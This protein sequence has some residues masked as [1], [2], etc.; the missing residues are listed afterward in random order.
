M[1]IYISDKFVPGTV[2]PRE[3]AKDMSGLEFLDKIFFLT[4]G[5]MFSQLHEI[6]GVDKST[7]QNWVNR[8]WVGNTVNKKYSKD[9]L[10]RII[11]I[12]MLRG[13][14]QLEKI[15]KLLKYINRTI[16]LKE[17]DII[18]ES[19]LYDYIWKI[20]NSL[21]GKECLESEKLQDVIKE[22]TQDYE[23]KII[24]ARERLNFAL[25]IIIIAYYANLAIMYSNKLY[26]RRISAAEE[27]K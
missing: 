1:N 22:I 21:E 4:D 10:A 3:S 15:D 19:E 5:I 13:S 6:S 24:G 11:I 16:D 26:D 2:I 25:E 18:P 9:Q 27:V 7:L 17:D 12:N 8:G 20:I 23:E 14:L